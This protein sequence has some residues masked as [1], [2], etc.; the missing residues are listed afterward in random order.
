MTPRE[1]S[2]ENTPRLVD[3]P[4]EVKIGLLMAVIGVVLVLAATVWMAPKAYL[5]AYPS[6]D[7]MVYSPEATL[8]GVGV[9]LGMVSTLLFIAVHEEAIR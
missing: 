9:V 4:L 1:E 3:A 7:A 2:T 6:I 5:G 8:L